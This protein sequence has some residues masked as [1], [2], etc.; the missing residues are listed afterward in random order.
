VSPNPTLLQLW[1]RQLLADAAIPL[2]ETLTFVP[3]EFERCS[4]QCADGGRL[5]FN[6]VV[7]DYGNPVTSIVVPAAGPSHRLRP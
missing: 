6:D 5:R 7:F 1:Q 3:V 2:P 4:W